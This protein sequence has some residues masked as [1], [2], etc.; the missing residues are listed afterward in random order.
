MYFT[1]FSRLLK[2]LMPNIEGRDSVT[3]PS[4]C[5]KWYPNSVL[6]SDSVGF[7]QCLLANITCTVPGRCKPKGCSVCPNTSKDD[8]FGATTTLTIRKKLDFVVPF[9]TKKMVFKK[10]LSNHARR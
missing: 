7:V 9:E 8:S 6:F 5:E 2:V 10:H 1:E 3:V 4:A